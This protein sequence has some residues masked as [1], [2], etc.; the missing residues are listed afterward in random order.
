MTL[1][2]NKARAV[3]KTLYT[4]K[5]VE[6]LCYQEHPFLALM[7]KNDQFYGHNKQIPLIYG[8]N[9]GRSSSF[10]KAQA[11]KGNSAFA[12]FF[13][14]RVSDYSIASFDAETVEASENDK[15][16]FVNLIKQE[17]DGA[18]MSAAQSDSQ[19][20]W[21]NGS[22]SIGEI[23]SI[24]VDTLT[25]TNVEDIIHYEIGHYLEAAA[26]ETSGATRVGI[27]KVIALD[28]DLGTITVDTK[29]TSLAVGDFLFTDGDRNSKMSGFEAWIPRIAP[30]SGDSFF[31]LDRS[32]DS[33]RLAGVRFNG[34]GM[35]NEEALVKGLARHSRE[36]AR[37]DFAFMNSGRW[38]DL[39][40]ELGSKVNYVDVKTGYADIGFRG[41]QV[42]AGKR[43][44]TVLCDDNVASDQ[45]AVVTRKSWQLDSLKKSIRILDLDGN[46][47]LR[48]SDADGYEL[49]VGGYKQVQC[50]APAYNMN[51]TF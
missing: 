44:I 4:P 43:T 17:V 22:G 34:V 3:L 6:N 36:G 48:E 20:I 14:T 30:T 31:G 2:L 37:P 19:A 49:R 29:S 9:R 21:G 16:A 38:G 27:M 51:I 12:A 10:A 18:M 35:S 24:S 1:D 13:T 26:L 41:V 40:L 5:A 46:K 28:R 7:Q 8:S 25:L 23:A 32:V 50:N 33:T 45:I 47:F 11:N 15:G 39:L 42:H